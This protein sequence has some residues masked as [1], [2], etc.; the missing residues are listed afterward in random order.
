MTIVF[1]WITGA[2]AALVVTTMAWFFFARTYEVRPFFHSAHA[3]WNHE[4]LVLFIRNGHSGSSATI[5]ERIGPP[6]YAERALQIDW[7]PRWLHQEVATVVRYQDGVATQATEFVPWNRLRDGPF[8]MDGTLHA[9]G[10]IWTGTRLEQ[11]PPSVYW[12]DY[13][14]KDVAMGDWHVATL[15]ENGSGTISLPLRMQA[16]VM[17]LRGAADGHRTTIELVRADGTVVPLWSAQTEL[18]SV[19][20]HAFDAIFSRRP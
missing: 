19:S 1:R 12:K 10:G 8:V 16:D 17:T 5:A 11:R 14:L 2:V 20:A 13:H 7:R 9:M 3:A 18:G 4:Q 15:L 6:R